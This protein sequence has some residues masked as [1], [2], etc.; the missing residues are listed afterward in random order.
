[1]ADGAENDLLER[2]A[3]DAEFSIVDADALRA[4]LDS[5]RY[6]GRAPEQAQDFSEGPLK[7]FLDSVT[8]YA[9][10]D[11]AKVTL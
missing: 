10:P 3:N 9:A 8:Q 5:S 7:E 2:L 1:M 11:E 4:Q 6:I